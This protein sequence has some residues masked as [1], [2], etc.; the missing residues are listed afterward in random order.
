MVYWPHGIVRSRVSDGQIVDRTPNPI[1]PDLIRTSPDGATVVT[2]ETRTYGPSK[3]S[4]I[5]LR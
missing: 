3:I 5:A 2:V 1:L 4:I